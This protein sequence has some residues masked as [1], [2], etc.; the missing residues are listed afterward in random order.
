VPDFASCEEAEAFLLQLSQR[1]ASQELDTESV[2]QVS[3]RV[4]DWIRSKRAGQ[5]LELKRIN[6]T[7]DIGSQQIVITGGLPALPGTDIIAPQLN[8]HHLELEANK[9]PINGP[10]PH[11]PEE[12]KPD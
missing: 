5:E 1:E 3:T 11:P 6:A 2:A 7:Q 12:N 4:L 8:G 10:Q 9:D